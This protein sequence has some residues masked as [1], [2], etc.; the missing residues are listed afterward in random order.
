MIAAE[1]KTQ[2]NVSAERKEEIHAG[3]L[4]DLKTRDWIS[5]SRDC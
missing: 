5:G 3:G 2:I 4:E 1:V